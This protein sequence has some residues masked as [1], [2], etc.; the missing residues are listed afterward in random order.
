MGFL[1]SVGNFFKDTAGSILGA[2]GGVVGSLLGAN[3]ND[4][5]NDAN[6]AFAR[7]QLE[8]QKEL[9]KNQIQ[10]KVED[11]KKAGLHP[12]AALG[13]SSMSYSPVSAGQVG[14]DYSGIG[15]SL[16]SMGQNIDRASM[17]AKDREQ[18]ERALALQERQA[19][20]Q[21]EN[22]K[23]QNDYIREQ[24]ATS[25]VN[26]LRSF[27]RAPAMASTGGLPQG[28]Y[29]LASAG[30]AD[31]K[32]PPGN[33]Y[34]GNGGVLFE[35][36]LGPDGSYEVW[37][38]QN[39]AQI[40]EDK[41][42]IEWIPF[43]KAWILRQQYKDSG[44]PLYVRDGETGQ[45]IKLGYDNKRGGFYP[46]ETIDLSDADTLGSEASKRDMR[47]F[48]DGYSE[49]LGYREGSPA[50]GGSMF[51]RVKSYLKDRGFRY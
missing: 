3:S 42:G 14:A 5:A 40:V 21:L 51:G 39:W 43:Y 44:M 31:S 17:A 10:W 23:L 50:R 15:N 7:E 49:F 22:M 37:P 13:L 45:V 30:Q 36:M 6:M 25:M 18:Q 4:R 41:L 38:S 24:I 32:I 29:S 48:F 16:M 11:A 46:Y 12:M 47:R 28:F 27:A 20:L 9:A 26:R 1:S 34:V 19:D 33:G 35:S 8:Y 2:A